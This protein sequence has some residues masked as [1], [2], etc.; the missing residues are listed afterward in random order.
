MLPASFSSKKVM[1]A[2]VR[3]ARP[4]RPILR[5]PA[6]AVGPWVRCMVMSG[7]KPW[8]FLACFITVQLHLS[9]ACHIT[10][11]AGRPGRCSNRRQ[12][13]T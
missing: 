11:H 4:V 5:P 6:Q 3:P 7:R 2:P 12:T 9:V 10:V 1:A 8:Q 13:H